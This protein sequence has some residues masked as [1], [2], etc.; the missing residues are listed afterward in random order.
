[1]AAEALLDAARDHRPLAGQEPHR[2][3]LLDGPPGRPRVHRS[4]VALARSDDPAAHGSGDPAR[5]RGAVNAGEPSPIPLLD[6]G[7]QYREIGAELEAAVLQVLRS[8]RYVLGETVARFEAAIA[9]HLG[10]R[11][12][13]GVA[14]GSD[15]LLLAL[16][17]LDVRVGAEVVTSPFSFF[18]TAAAVVRLGATPVFADIDPADFAVSMASVRLTEHT[19]A[20][21][22]VHLYGQCGDMRTLDAI[23]RRHRLPIVED[24]AQAIGASRDGWRVGDGD[25]ACLSFYPTKNLGA[26]GDAGLVVTGDDALAAR[27]RRLRTHGAEGRYEHLEVGLNSRLDAVQAAVL[28]VKLKYVESW[29]AARRAR[30]RDYDELF[31]AAGLEDEVTLPAVAPGATHVFHQYVIRVPR[32]EALRSHLAS[33]G[34][35]SEVYYPI[36]LHLQPCF[37]SLGYRRGDLPEAE[38]AA[39]EVLAL[40]IHPELERTAQERVVAAVREFYG[41]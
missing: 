21:L 15:A 29:N 34:I 9:E 25:L 33:R 5:S 8:G 23:A 40:P 35:A 41:R 28:T 27:V 30:A 20:L 13:I 22:P 26:V 39:D 3:A 1:M 36:P 24:A 4:V 18:A 12:A 10:V 37:A 6:L 17:A 32:R 19:R 2:P 7:A 16:M 31:R 11:H 38:R 14:S